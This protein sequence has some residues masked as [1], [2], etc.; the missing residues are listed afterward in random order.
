MT[1]D[2]NIQI[3]EDSAADVPTPKHAGGRPKGSK[4]GYTMSPEAIAV[5]N[6]SNFRTGS[7]SKKYQAM[8]KEFGIKTTEDLIKVAQRQEDLNKETME[9]LKQ[10]NVLLDQ[11][12]EVYRQMNGSGLDFMADLLEIE[13]LL[14]RL[15][16]K[17]IGHEEE[18]L[19]DSNYRWA[20]EQKTKIK[21]EMSKEE[22]GKAKIVVEAM[23]ETG[24]TDIIDIDVQPEDA[25]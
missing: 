10:H 19:E 15:R 21:K 16:Q 12:R 20:I 25:R 17:Y 24:D 3:V 8:L 4:S 1:D 22:L 11:T 23:K 9:L 14:L 13:R 7:R 6:V 2:L 5:R 18:L